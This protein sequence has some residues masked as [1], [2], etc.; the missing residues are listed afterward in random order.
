MWRLV[1]Q[2]RGDQ[3]GHREVE[4]W[5]APGLRDDIRLLITTYLRP[6]ELYASQVKQAPHIEDVVNLSDAL[7][8]QNPSQGHY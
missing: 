1:G 5:V 8:Y 7:A 4:Q 6:W 2:Y 3:T